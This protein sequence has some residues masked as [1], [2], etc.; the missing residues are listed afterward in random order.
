MK[1]ALPYPRHRA[2]TA[3]GRQCRWP[4]IPSIDRFLKFVAQDRPVVAGDADIL[5]RSIVR[6]GNAAIERRQTVIRRQRRADPIRSEV[7][8]AGLRRKAHTLLTMPRIGRRAV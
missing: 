8:D 7:R 5:A 2:R 1:S 4:R 3:S 6:S